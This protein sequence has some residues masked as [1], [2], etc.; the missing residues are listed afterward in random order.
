MVQHRRT[1]EQETTHTNGIAKDT[2]FS[3]TTERVMHARPEIQGYVLL[4]GGAAL[5]LF[6][7]GFLP[8]VKWLV[9]AAGA[10]MLLWGVVRSDVIGSIAR[11]IDRYRSR[12]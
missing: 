8:M 6:A 9:V 12:K 4:A 7:F 3:A 10:A 1:S 5:V 11:T 2:T